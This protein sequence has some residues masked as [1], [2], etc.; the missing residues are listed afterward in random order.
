MAAEDPARR[1][2]ELSQSILDKERELLACQ[3]RTSFL[4]QDLESVQAELSS[5]REELR[6]EATKC[7]LLEQRLRRATDE[8]ATC[9]TDLAAVTSERDTLHRTLGRVHEQ[10]TSLKSDSSSKSLQLTELQLYY[11]GLLTAKEA[12]LQSLQALMDGQEKQFREQQALWEEQRRSLKASLEDLSDRVSAAQRQ[13]GGSGV[14]ASLIADLQSK[15]SRAERAAAK[16]GEREAAL[17]ELLRDRERQIAKLQQRERRGGT[18]GA[19]G[20]GQGHRHDALH[21]GRGHDGDSSTTASSSSRVGP[22]PRLYSLCGSSANSSGGP[23]SADTERYTDRGDAGALLRGELE[24]GGRS[25]S[26]GAAVGALQVALQAER[27][28]H[29]KAQSRL[30]T[31]ER[32]G[33]DLRAQVARL[34]S[35]LADFLP[36]SAAGSNVQLADELLKAHRTIQDLEQQLRKARDTGRTPSPEPLPAIASSGSGSG[37]GGCL[38]AAEHVALVR[39]RLLRQRQEFEAVLERV[40]SELY[41]RSGVVVLVEDLQAALDKHLT[42]GA[43][44]MSR[45]MREW[46]VGDKAGLDAAVEASFSAGVALVQ[47]AAGRLQSHAVDLGVAR[48]QLKEAQEAVAQQRLTNGLVQKEGEKRL[49]EARNAAE[50]FRQQLDQVREEAQSLQRESMLRLKDLEAARARAEAAEEATGRAEAAL[51]S[52]EGSAEA[53]VSSREEEV[54]RLHR[55]LKDAHATIELLHTRLQGQ[56]DLPGPRQSGGGSQS[57]DDPRVL[58]GSLQSALDAAVS[59]CS[60]ALHRVALLEVAHYEAE[61]GVAAVAAVRDHLTS[62]TTEMAAGRFSVGEVM[63]SELLS[64]LGGSGYASSQASGGSGQM[65][66]PSSGADG[67]GGGSGGPLGLGSQLAVARDASQHLTRHL[68]NLEG[69]LLA[70]KSA[71]PEWLELA[72]ARQAA[73]HRTELSRLR[74]LLGGQLAAL[75]RDLRE[76]KTSCTQQLGDAAQQAG[77]ALQRAQTIAEAAD[78]DRAEAAQ[79]LAFLQRELRAATDALMATASVAARAS[80]AAGSAASGAADAASGAGSTNDSSAPSSQPSSLLSYSLATTVSAAARSV[81]ELRVGMERLQRDIAVLV[82]EREAAR[83]VAEAAVTHGSMLVRCIAEAVPLPEVLLMALLNTGSSPDP[84]MSGVWCGQLREC[85]ASHMA[86]VRAT[87]VERVVAEQVEPL[88]RDLERARSELKAMRRRVKSLQAD[89]ARFVADSGAA[90]EACRRAAGEAAAAVLESVMAG[91][92]EEVAHVR[93]Q[94]AELQE[95]STEALRQADAAWGAQLS[96]ARASGAAAVAALE[97]SVAALQAQLGSEADAL[98]LLRAESEAAAKEAAER[99]AIEASRARGLASELAAVRDR[100]ASLEASEASLEGEN[101]GP[102]FPAAAAPRFDCTT[103]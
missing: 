85:L 87:G 46:S 7:S 88:Q 78:R 47:E 67:A 83:A 71:L 24:A 93:A 20:H 29:E 53:A 13:P 26:G 76:L 5:A 19:H 81:P 82:S 6:N 33:D 92:R 23:E 48:Q 31:A 103:S 86:T 55:S 72:T 17:G 89:A 42:Q 57:D 63:L 79:Q 22:P 25:G 37:L 8:L 27:L 96:A 62:A 15:L 49:A 60:A 35:Q 36:G 12:S 45:L 99:L 94:L 41:S 30:A 97:H 3:E 39:Q 95:G 18:H 68:K 90:L 16:A 98:D 11:D 58:G 44:F 61:S 40:A 77:E 34:R 66:L 64:M 9:K 52:G 14:D 21:G 10:L 65:A 28:K 56:G 43:D 59:S 74:G 2:N 73:S 4:K 100:L 38:T 1:V 91:V 75:K 69:M 50:E 101:R 32:E 51:A 102:E 80:S 54:L 84:A 70:V